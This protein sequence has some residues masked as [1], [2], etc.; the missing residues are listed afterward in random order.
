[1]IAEQLGWAHSITILK[2]RLR[3]IGPEYA[4]GILR[5]GWCM[6]RA[7]QRSLLIPFIAVLTLIVRWL[8]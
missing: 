8:S 4:G 7:S 6:S 2:D 1:M 3:M 5:T